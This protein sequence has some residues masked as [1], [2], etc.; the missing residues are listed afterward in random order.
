MMLSVNPELAPILERLPER[1][2]NPY[3]DMPTLRAGFRVLIGERA[4]EHD[5]RVEVEPLAITGAAGQPM[6]GQIVRPRNLTGVLPGVLYLHG[7]GFA[8][9]ELEGPSPMVRDAAATVGAVVINPHYRLAPEHRFPAGVEDCYA[10]LMW[11][12]EHAAEIGV[13]PARVAV[14]GASAGGNLAA[15]LTLMSRDRGG[16]AI[17]FQSLLIP[18]LDDRGDTPSCRAITDRRIING[19]GIVHTWDTYLGPDRDPTTTSAY[20]APARAEDLRSLP[21][22]YILACGL[23]PLRDEDVDYAARLTRAE[24]TVT[25]HHVP[26]AWHFFEAYAPTTTIAQETTAH[27]LG[28]LRDALGNSSLA[29]QRPLRT[30]PGR[31]RSSSNAATHPALWT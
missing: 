3:L 27:W 21:P 12:T 30:L 14:C 11:F 20:A 22:A 19:P 29:P 26:G 9:G 25:L 8:Y 13:D 28:A 18:A 7:G 1:P 24:N 6:E 10:A 23:D 15:A 17:A 16:P 31:D 2:E 4:T 5:P